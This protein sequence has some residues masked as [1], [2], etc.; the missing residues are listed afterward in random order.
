MVKSCHDLDRFV[1][2]SRAKQEKLVGLYVDE[3]NVPRFQ[4]SNHALAIA[5]R[6]F[7]EGVLFAAGEEDYGFEIFRDFYL[8]AGEFVG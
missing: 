1:E 5:L 2:M 7:H 4:R 6:L 3:V 8:D